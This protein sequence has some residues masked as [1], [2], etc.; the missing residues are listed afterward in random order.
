[1]NKT[2]ILTLQPEVADLYSDPRDL[3]LTPLRQELSELEVQANN[4]NGKVN[5]KMADGCL[6]K[7]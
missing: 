2:C 1:M 5:I 7:T 6:T 4:G 3:E